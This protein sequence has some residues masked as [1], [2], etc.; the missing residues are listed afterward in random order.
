MVP[1]VFVNL[2]GTLPLCNAKGKAL[3]GSPR[4]MVSQR[5]MQPRSPIESRTCLW[6]RNTL[7]ISLFYVKKMAHILIID[8]EIYFTDMLSTM[9][10]NMGHY[11][12]SAYSI[13]GGLE[14]ISSQ[15]FDVVLLDVHLP[16][17]S[18]LEILPK[19][20]ALPSS[21]EV[22]IITGFGDPDGAELAI[23]NGA[24]DYIQ[25]PFS[26][27]TMTLLLTRALQYSEAK[28]SSRI[29]FLLKRD[30]IIGNSNRMDLC[31]ELLAKAA[32]SDA[33]VLI[34]GETGTGKELFARA[35]HK[36]SKRAENNFIIVDCAALPSTIVE[37]L[38]FGHEKGVFTGADKSREG[39]IKQ[40]DGGTLFLDEVGELPLSTQKTF[41][42][43]LHE[44]SF[45]PL[46]S[47]TEVK[48]DFR[49]VAATNK[50]LEDMVLNGSFRNDLLF[51]LRTISIELPPLR[52]HL[53][54][55]KDLIFYYIAKFCERYGNE[56]KGFSPDFLEALTTYDWPGNIRELVHTLERALAIAHNEPTLFQKHLPTD[57][58]IKLARAGMDLEESNVVKKQAVRRAP[59]LRIEDFRKSKDKEYLQDLMS[60]VGNNIKEACRLS[61]LSR[62]HLYALLKEYNLSR[63]E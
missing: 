25:K 48:S 58:R 41:L 40:A 55:I 38:L 27:Y 43:V 12:S 46:G 5:H 11:V 59:F 49:L 50:N 18:G 20:K 3:S 16:D 60:L 54:D 1:A 45:R 39:L 8:D 51:R 30:G 36:N 34:T 21:P 35:I 4:D 63:P 6:A 19:L 10:R 2:K 17:G 44:R 14:K 26:T 29:L 33:N 24:W 23:K 57:I 62:S 13:E 28:Q 56:I 37:S 9:V 15:P 47:K 52:E 32:A 22:I 53:E 61:C 7:K 42:R 31:I